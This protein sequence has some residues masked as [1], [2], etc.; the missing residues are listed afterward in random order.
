MVVEN[1]FDYPTNYSDA[2]QFEGDHSVNSTFGLLEYGNYATGGWLGVMIM[3]MV[4]FITLGAGIMTGVKKAFTAASF[5]ST[6]FA[7]MLFGL[8]LIESYWVMIWIT[9]TAIAAVGA[10]NEKGGF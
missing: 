10:F 5:I 1:W 8:G 4:F 3:I 9:M 6:I 7:I 2:N